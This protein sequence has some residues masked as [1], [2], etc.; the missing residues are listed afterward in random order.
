MAEDLLVHDLVIFVKLIKLDFRK[1]KNDVI[2]SR[3][4]SA[5]LPPI[6]T[7]KYEK[8][9]KTLVLFRNFNVWYILPLLEIIS[10][11]L[12]LKIHIISTNHIEIFSSFYKKILLD[13]KFKLN[14]IFYCWFVRVHHKTQILNG[15]TL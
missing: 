11:Q 3:W 13:E 2:F 7:H 1:T 12:T 8:F 6:L 14:I 5:L 4:T 15:E 9:N 10:Y